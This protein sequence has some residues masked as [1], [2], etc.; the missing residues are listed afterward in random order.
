MESPKVSVLHVFIDLDQKPLA[1]AYLKRGEKGQLNTIMSR[2]LCLCGQR[3]AAVNYHK[4]GK[5]YYR[6]KC[7]VCLRYGGVGKGLPK[8]FQ[9]GYRMK[10]L[11]DKCGFKSKF[12]EQFNVFHVDGNL[13]NSRP[14]NLKT[15]CANCQRVLQKEGVQ[16]RQGDLRPDF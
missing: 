9:D 7:E 5:T 4:E 8:W 6:K 13:N 2:P 1:Y 14:A 11:C 12:R 16:W 15:V 3:P 10:P